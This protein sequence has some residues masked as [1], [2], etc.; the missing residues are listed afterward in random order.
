MLASSTSTWP[1]L[2]GC[3]RPITEAATDTISAVEDDDRSDRLGGG[4]IAIQPLATPHS[5]IPPLPLP[6]VEMST[7][8]FLHLG[9]KTRY[10]QKTRLSRQRGQLTCLRLLL[11]MSQGA[12]SLRNHGLSSHQRVPM[13]RRNES[14]EGGLSA[15]ASGFC[16]IRRRPKTR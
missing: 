5:A 12:S 14:K 13:S 4:P 7:G 3:L 6:P 10:G 2:A 15:L 9:T 1:P 8:S 11:A 16:P